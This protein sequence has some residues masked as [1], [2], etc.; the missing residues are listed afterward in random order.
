MVRK[1]GI[2]IDKDLHEEAKEYASKT[3]RTFSG[4]VEVSVRDKLRGENVEQS[5]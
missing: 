4:L 3:G 1:V 2:S 5:P